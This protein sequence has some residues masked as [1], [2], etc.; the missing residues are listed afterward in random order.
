LGGGSL[1]NYLVRAQEQR[2][3]DRDAQR[4]RCLEI[5]HKLESRRLLDGQVRGLSPSEDFVYETRSFDDLIRT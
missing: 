4:F 2:R 1:L 3:W 5:D